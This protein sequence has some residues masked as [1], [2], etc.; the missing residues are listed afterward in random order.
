MPLRKEPKRE[1]TLRL[2]DVE[3]W[4]L[5]AC[6]GTHVTRTGA[7]GLIAV[8]SWERFKGGQRIEF[9]CGGRALRR[10]RT[11]RDAL[12]ASG[13]LLS[14]L[15][16][17]LAAAIERLQLEVKDRKRQNVALQ[18]ELSRF[19]ALELAAA[20]EE[21]AGVRLVAHAVDADANGLKSL[22]SAITTAPGFFVVLLS[23]ATPALAVVARSK[24]AAPSAQQV[25]T[26][27]IAKFGGRGGGKP[28]LAQGGGLTGAPEDILRAARQLLAQ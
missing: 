23:T 5:S 22:A 6:G 28:D 2:I 21:V 20:A 12:E 8:A 16:V 24:D 19:Q 17:E 27:L 4:D 15:P 10:F 11:Q 1:G 7:I 14:V 13:R 18:T 26:A 3:G 9:L 25:L